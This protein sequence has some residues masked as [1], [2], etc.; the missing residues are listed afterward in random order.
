VTLKSGTRGVNFFQRIS[1]ITFVYRLTYNDQIQHVTNGGE[2]R[3][4]WRQPRAIPNVRFLRNF[5]QN[6]RTGNIVQQLTLTLQILH[7]Y[8]LNNVSIFIPVLA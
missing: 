1:V 4:S 7:K 5:V 3:A 2:G 8:R 6:M